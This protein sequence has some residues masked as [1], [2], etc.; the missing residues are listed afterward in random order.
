LR[1][2][3]GKI[4]RLGLAL[5]LAAIVL[6]PLALMVA[7]AFKADELQILSDLG[8]VRAFYVLP[9]DMSLRHFANV[10]GDKNLPFLHFLTNSIVIIAFIVVPGIFIN[11][12]AGFALSRIR[13]QGRDL[14]LGVVVALII[15]PMES[16][17]VPLLLM[18]NQ[19]GWV[20]TLQA[21]IVPFIAH[22]FSIYLF[23]QFFSKIPKDLDDAAYVEGATPSQVYWI[24]A[25]PL[26][27]PVIATVAILQ[28]LEF[29]N[30]Y[31]WP[32]MVTRGPDAQPISL[33]LAQFFTGSNLPRWGDIMAL[34]LIHI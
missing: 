3:F 7:T 33:G 26:S 9:G 6:A 5:L 31:L 18:V 23:Y 32:I 11:S 19:I 8:S 17:A 16:L 13:F 1:F 34:S 25:L 12:A 24:I 2:R 10:L 30:A 4:V 28:T 27:L 15:I 20:N 22:P 21:Q 14:V 29:W